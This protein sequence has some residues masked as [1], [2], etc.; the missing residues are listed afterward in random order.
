MTEQPRDSLPGAAASQPAGMKDVG[1]VLHSMHVFLMQHGLR[2]YLL[3]LLVALIA[4]TGKSAY[5]QSS[6]LV[7]T[8]PWWAFRL[9]SLV[10]WSILVLLFASLE[11]AYSYVLLQWLGGRKEGLGILLT[12]FRSWRH[13]ANVAIAAG[14]PVILLF[15]LHLLWISIPWQGG[16]PLINESSPLAELLREIP[17]GQRLGAEVPDLVMGV[18]L[19]PF[20]WAGIEA[21]VHRRSWLASLRRSVVL[22][23]RFRGLAAGYLLVVIVV[24]MICRLAGPVAW[25]TMGAEGPVPRGWP[26]MVFIAASVVQSALEIAIESCALVIAYRGMLRREAETPAALPA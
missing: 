25:V 16:A 21:L 3:A 14:L 4:S 13:V 26:T 15:F 5:S 7:S 1:S 17:G 12:A 9:Q 10:C 2:A 18:L 6:Y 22:V 24:P 19:V 8:W 11:T 20:A 23:L